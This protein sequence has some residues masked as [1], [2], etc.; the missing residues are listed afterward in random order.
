[1]NNTRFNKPIE[2]E[3]GDSVDKI[4]VNLTVILSHSFVLSYPAIVI[5]NIILLAPDLLVNKYHVKE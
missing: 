1:M 5:T 3:S 2:S 4:T